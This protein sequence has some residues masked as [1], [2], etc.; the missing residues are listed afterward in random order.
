MDNFIK[1]A[2]DEQ[3]AEQYKEMELNMLSEKDLLIKQS[4]N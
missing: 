1:V 4:A 2:Q 3:Q